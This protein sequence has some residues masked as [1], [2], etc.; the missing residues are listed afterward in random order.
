MLAVS[1][2]F[3]RDESP[4]IAFDELPRSARPT[5]GVLTTFI[6]DVWEN[7]RIGFPYSPY[8]LSHRLPHAGYSIPLSPLSLLPFVP[9]WSALVPWVSREGCSRHDRSF[10]ICLLFVFFPFHFSESRLAI[11]FPPSLSRFLK[12][13]GVNLLISLFLI[14]P[15]RQDDLS[16]VVSFFFHQFQAITT[17]KKRNIR[18]MSEGYWKNT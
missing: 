2:T 4:S 7:H 9:L 11:H 8:C 18:N 12:V 1:Q 5:R 17:E 6:G 10:N 15:F 13:S 16:I 14:I 3:W